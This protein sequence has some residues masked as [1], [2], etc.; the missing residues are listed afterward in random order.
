MFGTD[1]TRRGPFHL[2]SHVTLFH[3]EAG[4]VCWKLLYLE[5]LLLH[6]KRSTSIVAVSTIRRCHRILVIKGLHNS[7]HRSCIGAVVAMEWGDGQ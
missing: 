6:M 2:L 4:L 5:L 7:H 3:H 1:A